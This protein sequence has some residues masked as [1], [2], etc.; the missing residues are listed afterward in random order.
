LTTKLSEI[1]LHI[2]EIDP[3]ALLGEHNKKIDLVQLAFPDLKINSR[4]DVIL[5][6]KLSRGQ[7]RSW[8]V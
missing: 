5:K 7:K 4:G 2:G 3:L 1:E 8:K 6:K